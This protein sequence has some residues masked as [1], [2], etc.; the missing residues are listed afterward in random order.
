VIVEFSEELLKQTEEVASEL[1]KNRSELIRS[2]VKSYIETRRKDELEKSLAEGYR[3]Y[4]EF[5]RQIAE[6]FKYSDDDTL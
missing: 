5:N 3:T 6:E 2:A 4:A 1:S